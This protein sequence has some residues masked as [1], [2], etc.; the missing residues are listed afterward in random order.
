[1]NRERGLPRLRPPGGQ[2]A[3]HEPATMNQTS[4]RLPTSAL[5]VPVGPDRRAG[6]SS[7]ASRFSRGVRGVRGVSVPV[8]PDRR[9]GRYDLE[10]DATTRRQDNGSR[11]NSPLGQRGALSHRSGSPSSRR[12]REA[13]GSFLTRSPRRVCDETVPA[14]LGIYIGLSEEQPPLPLTSH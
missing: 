1:M 13:P 11:P 5:R 7:P 9:A 8:G 2:C 14:L 12:P 3:K 4:R 6:L 10:D